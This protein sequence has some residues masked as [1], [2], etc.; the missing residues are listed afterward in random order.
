[1]GD[2]SRNFSHWEF[3]CPCQ[4]ATCKN[5]FVV[6]QGLLNILQEIA[7][8]VG[9]V[10]VTSGHRCPDHNSDPNVGGARRSWHLLRDRKLYAADIVRMDPRSRTNDDAIGMYLMADRRD[11][12]G[13]GLYDGGR[14]HVDTRPLRLVGPPRHKDATRARWAHEDFDHWSN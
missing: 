2:L 14:I 7:N 8:V 1:M 11:A 10:F 12:G 3:K 6:D 9:P 4:R 5:Q 13:L